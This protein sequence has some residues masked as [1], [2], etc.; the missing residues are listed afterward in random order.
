MR[1]IGNIK[2]KGYNT[3]VFKH[4]TK[5]LV[6]FETDLFE[7][8]YKFRETEQLNSLEAIK[9]LIDIT[10]LVKV[11]QRFGQMYK[12]SSEMLGRF[13]EATEENWEEII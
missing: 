6:K 9:E 1:V 4:E 13:I 5:F 12:D 11:E 7:Q 10:F 3:T 2:T 8:I